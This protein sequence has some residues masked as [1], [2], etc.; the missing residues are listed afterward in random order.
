M[1]N[2]EVF[3]PLV[4]HLKSI[5][6]FLFRPNSGNGGDAVIALSCMEIFDTHGLDWQMYT[7]DRYEKCK[8]IVYSGGATFPQYFSLSKF[9]SSHDDDLKS[10]TLMPHSFEGHEQ[11]I[12]NMDDRYHLFAREKT[13]F[14]YLENTTK[15]AHCYLSHDVAFSLDVNAF[16]LPTTLPL[17]L[18]GQP[19]NFDLQWLFKQ[20]T[21][22]RFLRK[23]I[24]ESLYFRTDSES[25]GNFNF[26]KSSV[27]LSRLIKGKM[28][29]RKQ[30]NGIALTFLSVIKRSQKIKTDRLHVGICAGLFGIPCDLYPGINFKINSIHE[31]S[32]DDLLSGVRMLSADEID[33]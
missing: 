8:S 4:N 33:C 5:G 32:I 30:I 15:G 7:P 25:S 17:M 26:N 2:Y 27:D 12:A 23:G 16:K 3:E 1:I 31:H 18:P 14:D 11:L 10:F 13:T 24:K 6:P 20:I 28:V 21:L 29:T 22:R 9:V 19:I